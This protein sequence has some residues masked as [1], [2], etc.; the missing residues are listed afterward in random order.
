MAKVRVIRVL[1]YIGEESWLNTT[2]ANRACG[3]DTPIEVPSLGS[4]RELVMIR[5]EVTS[6]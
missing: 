2:L 4:V 6:D 3:A 5:A 1:E